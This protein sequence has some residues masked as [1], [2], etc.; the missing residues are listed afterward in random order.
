MTSNL[1]F[2]CCSVGLDPELLILDGDGNIIPASLIIPTSAT[3]DE[4]KLVHDNAAIEI[5]TTPD[6][7]L[8]VQGD[9]LRSTIIEAYRA[10]RLAKLRKKIN[11]SATI[12]YVPSAPI[13]EEYLF[14][15]DHEELHQFGCSPSLVLDEKLQLNASSPDCDPMEVRHRC[16][17][18]HMHIGFPVVSPLRPIFPADPDAE[19]VVSP[20]EMI[21]YIL[22]RLALVDIY[23]GLVDVMMCGYMG[24]EEQSR[25]RRSLMGYGKPGEIR[26]G[27]VHSCRN[28]RMEYRTLSPWPLSH[29]MWTWWA[30][31]AFRQIMLQPISN[32]AAMLKNA[33]DRSEVI[34]V[35]TECD[36]KAATT[37]W[38]RAVDNWCGITLSGYTYSRNN[39]PFDEKPLNLFNE[40]LANGGFLAAIGH[41]GFGSSW[42]WMKPY[43]PTSSTLHNRSKLRK[44]WDATYPY[45][46]NPYKPKVEVGDINPC[47]HV[48]FNTAYPS[49]INR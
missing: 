20:N 42:L 2:L 34:R 16:A 25:I 24:W 48:S 27:D 31:A 5:R 35:I 45:I 40:V 47:G 46:V 49:I 12:S 36:V 14:H 28:A 30:Q 13:T 32:V 11:P 17:G 29:P 22:P 23:V 10:F 38:Q 44:Q 21:D 9:N 33:P 19:S 4:E 26:L 3:D 18:F 41:R 8:E 1:K 15:P 7:C 6:V 37:L 39:Q 43:D